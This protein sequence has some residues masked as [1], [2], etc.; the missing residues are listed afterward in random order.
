MCWQKLSPIGRRK[1]V[2]EADK[3]S[4]TEEGPPSLTPDQSRAARHLSGYAQRGCVHVLVREQRSSSFLHQL[5]GMGD[6]ET[7]KRQSLRTEVELDRC[8][9]AT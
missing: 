4:A 5:A 1:A 7:C 8:L 2:R 3:L 9:R 6:D